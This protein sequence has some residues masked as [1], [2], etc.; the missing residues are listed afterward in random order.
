[1]NKNN[2][3]LLSI[4]SNSLLIMLKLI[5]GLSMGSI[6]V[7]SEAIHSSV[8]LL[9][10]FIAYFSIK[11]AS[12]APDYNHPFGHGKYENVSGF[13]EAIL[14][15]FASVLIIFES[16]KK[17]FSGSSVDNINTGLLVMLV[18]ALVNLVISLILMKVAK[19]SH[20][21][22]LEADAMHLLTDVLTAV[23]V[24]AGL[25][26]VK[27][28]GLQIID[29]IAA[30]LVSILIFKT[31]IDLT[32]KSIRDLVDSKLSDEEISKIIT[33]ISSH[34]DIKGFHKLRTRRN[35]TNRE[36][37]IHLE[38]SSTFS[39]IQAHDLC[40]HIEKDIKQIFPDSNILIHPEPSKNIK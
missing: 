37:D 30:I 24:L 28:T 32:K 14:I 12:K 40:I 34:T 5:S 11:K 3:A 7:I 25:L 33:I 6:S 2:A 35:G 15:L 1:M 10:S 19:N 9:A 13:A 39:L 29:P 22:A 18:S 26:L 38:I 4:I 20:S 27:I 21:I 17:I 23:G 36:I 31:S 16:V 8:D